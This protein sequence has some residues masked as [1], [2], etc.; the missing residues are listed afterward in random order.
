MDR[1]VKCGAD[2]D[3]EGRV[4]WLILSRAIGRDAIV[5]RRV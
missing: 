4:L 5:G 2:F 1:C 3:E